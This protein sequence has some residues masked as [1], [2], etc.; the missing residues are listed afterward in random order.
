MYAG[1]A[2]PSTVLS[3]FLS[4]LIRPCDGVGE[5]SV[6]VSH[7][8]RSLQMFLTHDSLGN[9]GDARLY[10]HVLECSL[11]RTCTIPIPYRTVLFRA[12]AL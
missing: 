11:V 8:S 3:L 2:M 4:F 5:R 7:S 10:V 12:G 9:H 1:I 6:K